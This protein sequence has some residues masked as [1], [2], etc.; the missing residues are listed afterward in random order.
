MILTVC[1][2]FATNLLM[3]N[4]YHGNTADYVLF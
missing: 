2:I 3:K 1:L 4:S